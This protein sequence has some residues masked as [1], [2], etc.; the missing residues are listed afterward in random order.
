MKLQN[1]FVHVKRIS[2]VIMVLL[3]VTVLLIHGQVSGR[4]ERLSPASA[5]SI[6]T[7]APNPLVAADAFSDAWLYEKELKVL[8]AEPSQNAE[9]LWRLA[10]THVDIGENL[11]GD[12]ALEFFEQGR[13]EALLAVEIDPINA[14]AHQMLAVACGR[15]ALYKG[16][17]KAPKLV[18]QTHYHALQAVALN[19]SMPIAL[20]ILGRTHQKLMEK[21]SL[22]RNL[23]GLGWARQDSIGYYFERALQVSGGNMVQCRVDYA[24]YLIGQEKII[25]ARN[26]LQEALNLP[27]RDEH[28]REYQERAWDMLKEL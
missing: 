2:P 13:D 14:Y 8:R 18:K 20:Y 22:T 25:E 27:L 11:Q 7:T 16:I 21:S 17:F 4:R 26:M 19:D 15:V 6:A 12:K 10:R 23:V 28:D 9:I 24:D 1:Q 5:D 3:S